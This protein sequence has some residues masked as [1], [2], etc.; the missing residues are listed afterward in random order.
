MKATPKLAL[1]AVG[2]GLTTVATPQWCLWPEAKPHTPAHGHCLVGRVK[3][4]YIPT[5]ARVCALTL[6]P[7]MNCSQWNVPL[8]KRES[9]WTD[10]GCTGPRISAGEWVEIG[11]TTDARGSCSHEVHLCGGSW[12][13]G[14]SGLRSPASRTLTRS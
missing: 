13:V 9:L 10:A 3:T 12:S 14:F 1:I 2:V 11:T 5:V 6:N 7:L 8:K 4:K